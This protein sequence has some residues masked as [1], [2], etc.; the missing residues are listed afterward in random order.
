MKYN[1]ASNLEDLD[2]QE[3]LNSYKSVD[4]AMSRPELWHLQPKFKNVDYYIQ[5]ID[6]S[7]EEQIKELLNECGFKA[8]LEYEDKIVSVGFEVDEIVPIIDI[9]K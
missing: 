2:V 1:T 9:T 5:M 3:E 6:D 7:E 4:N 8:W